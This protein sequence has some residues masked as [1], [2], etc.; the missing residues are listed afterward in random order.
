MMKCHE[1]QK[2]FSPYLD[3]ELDQTKTFEV[4]QHLQNCTSCTRRFEAERR[5][6]KLMVDSLTRES[7]PDH[8]WAHLCD[9]VAQPSWMQRFIAPRN[10]A[11]AAC[12]ALVITAF[13]MVPR[14][15]VQARPWLVSELAKVSD[16]PITTPTTK[17]TLLEAQRELLTRF[18]ISFDQVNAKAM[19]PH[20]DLKLVSITPR[21]DQHGRTFYEV[22][23]NCCNHPMLLAIADSNSHPLPDPLADIPS[24]AFNA[25]MIVDN[26]HLAVRQAGAF[27]VAAASTHP[28]NRL[29]D[30]MAS[31]S[32]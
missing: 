19:R 7:M 17:T 23:L 11:I 25:G 31:V 32:Y 14:N 26:T 24:E 10:L 28:V 9:T 1:A 5:A 21:Q 20:R 30:M 18:G 16:K 12:L 6:D 13:M 27:I 8:V 22:R 2:W 4:S 3:S 15:T 29:L